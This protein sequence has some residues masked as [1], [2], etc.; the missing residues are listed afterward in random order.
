MAQ[1]AYKNQYPKR[2]TFSASDSCTDN[3]KTGYTFAGWNAAA[4]DSGADWAAGGG[5]AANASAELYAKSTNTIVPY[6]WKVAIYGETQGLDFSRYTNEFEVVKYISINNGSEFDEQVSD[7]LTADVICVG[8]DD[9][10]SASTAQS[11]EQAV[12]QDGKI[13]LINFFSDELFSESLPAVKAGTALFGSAIHAEPRTDP[14]AAS[15]LEGLPDQWPS[16]VD[17]MTRRS[18]TAKAGS[19]VVTHFADDNTPALVV[20]RY[21]TGVVVYQPIELMSVFYGD[22]TDQIAYQALKWALAQLNRGQVCF[23]SGE[24]TVYEGTK[25]KIRVQRI[26]GSDGMISVQYKTVN[27]KALAW[28]DYTPKNGQVTWTNGDAAS[29]IIKIPITADYTSEGNEKFKVVL[30]GP[31]GGATLAAPSKAVITIA[32]NTKGGPVAKDA[33]AVRM[34]K[35]TA[36][37]DDESLTWFMSEQAPWAKQSSITV[38]GVDAAISSTGSSNPSWLQTDLEGSGKLEFDWMLKATGKD[39]C[40]VYVNGKVRRTLTPGHDWEHET[41]T[42]GDGEHIVRWVFVGD[43]RLTPGAAYLDQMKWTPERE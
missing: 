32:A 38:D 43:S 9:T 33:V 31:G 39:A 13:L 2:L 16:S 37:L 34:T 5:Y 10:F 27:I 7:Y 21:G 18:V 4:N 28:Q 35:L 25:K 24:C 20:W 6:R 36:A 14:I 41:L 26:G 42:L 22:Q 19:T 3:Q 17:Y 8:G 12:Y 29:K 11:I 23:S 30:Y 40:L 15:I 1:I